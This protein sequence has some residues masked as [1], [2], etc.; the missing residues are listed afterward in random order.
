MHERESNLG[1]KKYI[2][3]LNKKVYRLLIPY[4][5]VCL[6]WSNPIKII[7]GIPEFEL[8]YKILLQQLIGNNCGHLWYLPCLFILI[9][10]GYPVFCWAGKNL[11]KHTI[12][13]AL[14]LTLNYYHTKLPEVFQLKNVAYYF[15]FFH[16]GFIVNLLR[17]TKLEYIPK[18]QNKLHSVCILIIVSIV[19]YSIRCVTSIG[20]ECYLSIVITLL[21]YVLMPSFRNNILDEISNRSYG[22]Y[23]FHS[24]LIYITATLCPNINPWFML[25]INFIVLGVIAYFITMWLS[26]S[27]LKFIIGQL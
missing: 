2:N 3:Y 9:A 10:L 18:Y 26:N 20:F 25:I 4:I 27:K 14:L 13:F 1:G 15:I 21:L 6:F 23:L 12:L 16:L 8:D 22:L 24:P 17:T 5:F 19:G 7:L 11:T